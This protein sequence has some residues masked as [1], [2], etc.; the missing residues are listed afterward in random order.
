MPIQRWELPTVVTSLRRFLGL[1]NH[2]SEYIP[3]YAELAAP[4]QDL[5]KL[6]RVAGKK[7]SPFKLTWSN[8]QIESFRKVKV[9]AA[10]SLVFFS[11]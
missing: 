1:T 2:Y 5:L 10:G 8:E 9:A 11:S 7:G 6:D 4:M 3:R